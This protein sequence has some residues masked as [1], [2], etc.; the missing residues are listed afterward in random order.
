M[1]ARALNVYPIVLFFNNFLLR[2][3]KESLLE[4]ETRS[5]SN[6]HGGELGDRSDN[7]RSTP[8][9]KWAA[10]DITELT[11]TP[12]RRKDLKIRPN[13]AG[14]M[15]FSG[16]RGAVSVGLTQLCAKCN[17]PNT[18]GHQ[19]DFTMTT[20][21]IVLITV[22]V[23]GG[24]TEF[25][26]KLFGIDTG[27]DEHTYM[28]DTLLEPIVPST[29]RNF[30]SRYICPLVIRDYRSNSEAMK[31]ESFAEQNNSFN[32]SGQDKNYGRSEVSHTDDMSFVTQDSL[33][34]Y[35]AQVSNKSI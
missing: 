1:I 10:S 19:K 12:L 15:W 20:M 16:L 3:N 26:L 32:H 28:R 23:L 22:F 7:G 27:V 33:F 11:A 35:G 34:D 31:N 8:N 17:L 5:S 13:I 25:A 9:L 6:M 21:A 30:E 4:H 18:L 24:A 14:F 29:I 2:D